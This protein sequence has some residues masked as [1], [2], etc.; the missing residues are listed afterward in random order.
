M[1][2]LWKRILLV[3]VI[4]VFVKLFL[5]SLISAP[6]APSDD[7]MYAKMA[8]SFFH[9]GSLSVHGVPSNQYPPLYPIMISLSYLATDMRTAFFLMKFINILLSSLIILPAFFLA[10]EFFDDN[11]SLIIAIIIAVMPSNFSFSGYIL[12]ENLFYPLF[13]T[14]FY[15]VYKSFKDED[16]KWDILA[17]IFIGLSFLTRAISLALVFAVILLFIYLFFK[18]RARFSNKVV[19]GLFFILTLLPWL[20]RNGM[21]Y[22]FNLAGFLGIYAS[23]E[24]NVFN[25]NFPILMLFLYWL[26]VYS[27]YILIACFALLPV[28]SLSIFADKN[29]RTYFLLSVFTIIFVKLAAINHNLYIPWD[30]CSSEYCGLLYSKLMGRY[31]D[32]VLPIIIINGFVGLSVMKRNKYFKYVLMFSVPFFMASFVLLFYQLFPVNNVMLSWLGFLRYA[33]EFVFYHKTSFD[34][35]FNL[36]SFILFSLF[37][38]SLV[39]LILFFGRK[40]VLTFRNVSFFYLIFMF[41]SSILSYGMTYYNANQWSN[42]P[43]VEMGLWFN[44]NIKSKDSVVMFDSRDQGTIQKSG[45]G[46][47]EAFTGNRSATIMGFWMDD[48]IIIGDVNNPGNAD[49]IVSKHKLDFELI[50]S[51]DDIYLYRVRG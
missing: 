17:G 32:A 30:L 4:L 31:V 9:H 49:Y 26:L 45:G 8:W 20:L 28:L 12:A 46:L 33:F 24:G 10:R 50:N 37:F 15:F 22:G 11:K 40:D 5:A 14:A 21:L 23:S 48:N 29:L 47:Y 44:D 39:I 6:S 43:Q 1:K 35:A 16:Y 2:A 36:M 41:F 19:M 38:V 27:V 3:L 34:S 51:I 18:R 42:N 7:Y 25:L 13:L